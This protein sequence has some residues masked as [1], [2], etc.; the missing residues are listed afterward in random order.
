M[1]IIAIT[2]ARVGSTRL[3]GKV[4]KKV[5]GKT[6][7][8]IHINRILKAS[9]LDTLIVAT[10]HE[11][12]ATEIV[13]IANQCKIQSYQGSTEDVLDRFYQ[14]AQLEKPDWVVRVTS[15]CP[16][17]DPQLIDAVIEG[18][19]KAGADYGTNTFNDSFP[20]GQDIEVFSYEALEL[21]WKNAQLTSEREHVTPYIRKNTDKS[22][23]DIFKAFSF[24]FGAAYSE[25]R[26]TVDEEKDFQLA[27]IV[28]QNMGTD[29][30]W[31]EY[32]KYIADH[33]LASINSA[34]I[35]NEGYQKSLKKDE[36]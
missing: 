25:I 20:D 24:T 3:P 14:A 17:I 35:R 7:L 34:I 26:M 11:A 29:K 9:K 19:I 10:T 28:I 23:G 12:E 2:Q 36:Q 27:K 4:L 13:K 33:N 18:T 30:S 5:D 16:L 8:E 32:A 22:G 1:K 6:L 15:D 31:F 21:A